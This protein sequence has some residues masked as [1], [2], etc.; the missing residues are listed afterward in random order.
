MSNSETLKKYLLT[1][2]NPYLLDDNNNGKTIM[3]SGA[4]GSGKTHFWQNEIEPKLK[5]TQIAI[6]V[7]LYGKESINEI[8]FDIFKEAYNSQIKEDIISKSAS[9]FHSVAP[10]F[11]EKSL[12]DG[13]EKLNTNA[14]TKKATELLQQG[15][16]ICFDDFERKSEK[17]NLNDLFG[18]I[19]QLSIDLNCKTVIILNSDVFTGKEAKVFSNVKEKTISKFFHFNP[20]IEELFKSISEN[21][22]YAIL[23]DYKEDIL[24]AIKE[25]EELN[26]R[27][28][29]QVLD[30]CLEWVAVK[31]VFDANI[32]RVLILSTFNFILNHIILDYKNITFSSNNSATLRYE[33][34][35]LLSF[36]YRRYGIVSSVSDKKE[37]RTKSNLITNEIFVQSILQSIT[38]TDS[39]NKARF[40][41][42]AQE[43]YIN[44]LM[45]NKSTITALH[46]YG[47]QL[48][49]VS[50]VSEDMYNKI[51]NF[52]KTGILLP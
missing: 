37:Y 17:I 21:S 9:L 18:F 49:Y 52:I 26:A 32:I 39:N 1:K 19:S 44:W 51:K 2:E 43:E 3:L 11:G 31:K 34:I 30:N 20:T 12:T 42:K 22:K 23:N 38:S 8:K 45:M 33:L 15:S 24:S 41:D 28:Y 10:S 5:E 47:H 27:I 36:I 16:I 46:K 7:S 50:D 35:P 13:F 6:Y 14:K 40:T 25:T 29:I 4:W 48:Y